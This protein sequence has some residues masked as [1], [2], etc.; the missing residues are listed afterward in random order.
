MRE[1]APHQYPTEDSAGSPQRPAERTSPSQE[2]SWIPYLDFVRELMAKFDG[3]FI[4]LLG[5]QN[6]NHGLWTIAVLACQD[7]FKTYLKLDPGDMTMY[8]SIVHLPWSIKIVYG[9][10]SDNVPIAGTRRKS[11]I[12]LMG[13][14]QFF[15]LFLMFCMNASSAM[16][17]ALLLTMA[18]LSEAFVNVVSDAIMCT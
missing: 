13:L 15:A 18:A 2:K 14:L 7:L 9:L 8:M 12:V 11:Y 16:G 1:P 6:I 17:A 4:I 5:V 3:P 10:L